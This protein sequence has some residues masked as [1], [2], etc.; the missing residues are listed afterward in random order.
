MYF[1]CN[2]IQ[3]PIIDKSNSDRRSIGNKTPAIS[4]EYMEQSN[5]Q[6]T[7]SGPLSSSQQRQQEENPNR[8]SAN[9]QQIQ[10]DMHERGTTTPGGSNAISAPTNNNTNFDGSS[11]SIPMVLPPLPTSIHPAPSSLPSIMS[12]SS[13]GRLLPFPY[14]LHHMLED[15]ERHGKQEIVSWMPFGRSFK[16]HKPDKFVKEV[17]PI[18][19]NLK[20]Y[21]SFKRQ[22]I[23]YGFTKI[24]TGHGTFVLVCLV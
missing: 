20:Q 1:I 19:F 10:T 11:G 8:D 6:G 7:T 2:N 15:V 5:A 13:T 3:E 17:A 12:S 22:L 21:K 14:R 23:N 18:Y 4:C 9:Q 16:V 24:E